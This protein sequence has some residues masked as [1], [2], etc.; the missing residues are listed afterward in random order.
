MQKI[1][2]IKKFYKAGFERK[3]LDKLKVLMKE[4][5]YDFFSKQYTALTNFLSSEDKGYV[6]LIAFKNY[7][8]KGVRNKEFERAARNY[9]F[10]ASRYGFKELLLPFIEEYKKAIGENATKYQKDMLAVY[11]AT[12]LLDIGKD[13]EAYEILFDHAPFHKDVLWVVTRYSSWNMGITKNKKKLA[14]AMDIKENKLSKVEKKIKKK[15]FYDVNEN[16]V[17]YGDSPK[18]VMQKKAE[19][20]EVPKVKEST[21]KQDAIKLLD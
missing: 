3:A 8:E 5:T 21:P 2:K 18:K 4:D 6:N 19:K 13:A 17:K 12:Y 7:I 16:R 20:I 14:V 11:M 1:E 10:L 15:F 9:F